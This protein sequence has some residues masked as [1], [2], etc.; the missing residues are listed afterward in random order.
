MAR[1]NI[2]FNNYQNSQEQQ[3]LHDL[4]NEAVSIYGINGY[5][6]SRTLTNFDKIY[7]EDDQS[8]YDRAWMIP[9]YLKSV[10]GYAG[11]R[12]F[13]SKFAGLEIRDQI[14]L[15]LP[16][17]SFAEEVGVDTGFSRPRE[18]DVIYFPLHKKC[19]QIRYVN[20]FDVFFPLGTVTHWEMTAELFELSSEKFNTGIPE[21][22]DALN[23]RSLNLLDYALQ[24]DA[25]N[26]LLNPD[27]SLLISDKYDMQQIVPLDDTKE[28][29]T[30][31]DSLLDWSVQDP[32]ADLPNKRI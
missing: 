18:G 7:G 13:M 3:I 4:V 8:V 25:G 32:F 6:I 24:D 22:D 28:L 21:I 20:L 2:F 15:A 29:Q 27:S 23:A 12:D 11:D 10:M 30:E 16:C 14:S 26:P 17:R 31:V 19:F 9:Y 5:Y 1:S